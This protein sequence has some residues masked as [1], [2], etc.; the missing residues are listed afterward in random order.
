MC[1]G[2]TYIVCAKHRASNH[3]DLPSLWTG[4]MAHQ[5]HV[6]SEEPASAYTSQHDGNPT[7]E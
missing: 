6:E 1:A 5:L 4:L 3:V 2:Q 7:L